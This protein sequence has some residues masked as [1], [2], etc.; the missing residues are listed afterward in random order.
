MNSGIYEITNKINGNRYVGS[1]VD[2]E[3]RFKQHRSLLKREGHCNVHLQRAWN[4]YDEA[5]FEFSVIFYCAPEMCVAFEQR[6]IDAI[7]PEYNFCKVAGSNLGTKHTDEARVKMSVA[8]KGRV[9][10]SE[11]RANMGAAQKGRKHSEET[12]AKMSLSQRG[13]KCKPFTEEHRKNLSAART[14]SKHSAETIA[15][16]SADRKG[17]KFSKEWRANLRAARKKSCRL[18]LDQIHEIRHLLA[19][20]DMLQ[21]EIAEHYPVDRTAISRISTGHAYTDW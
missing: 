1:S 5:S 17:R 2:L 7:N 9:V 13:R 12:L 15:K 4:K 3:R 19:L 11:A 10:S 20:G 6:A 14:G 16:M 8:N 21:L 18:T